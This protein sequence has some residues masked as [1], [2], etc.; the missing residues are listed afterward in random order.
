M[1]EGSIQLR[2][3]CAG[4]G[5]GL[6]EANTFARE[7]PLALLCGRQLCC[8]SLACVCSGMQRSPVAEIISAVIVVIIVNMFIMNGDAMMDGC[9]LFVMLGQSGRCGLLC[10]DIVVHVFA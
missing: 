2:L 1:L 8:S 10:V 5:F 7:L 9:A 3:Q 6:V 4:A